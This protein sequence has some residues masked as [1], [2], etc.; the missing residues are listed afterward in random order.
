MNTFLDVTKA[1]AL[2]LNHAGGPDAV[3]PHLSCA[4]DVAED[5]ESTLDE[6]GAAIGTSRERV[7]QVVCKALETI[8]HERAASLLEAEE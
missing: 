6:I 2:R 5:R 3:P 8:A 7:R 1:G 4:L